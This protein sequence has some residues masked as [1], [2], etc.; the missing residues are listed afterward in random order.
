MGSDAKSTGSSSPSG[1]MDM[2]RRMACGGIAGMIAKVSKNLQ[3]HTNNT[4]F[5]SITT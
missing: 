2:T 4:R 5:V 3:K 1:A